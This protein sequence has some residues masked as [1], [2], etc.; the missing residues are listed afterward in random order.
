[1]N[2]NAK[3][4]FYDALSACKY[5]IEFTSDISYER[6]SGDAKTR[7][8]VERQFEILG[9]ALNRIRKI[10]PDLLESLSDWQDIIAFRNIVIHAYDKLND[11]IVFDTAINDIPGLK[12]GLEAV[13][14]SL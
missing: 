3:V 12:N 2:H 11:G 1:M 13:L 6:Y 9:E 10:S 7:F 14:A 5:I 4:C 8:A